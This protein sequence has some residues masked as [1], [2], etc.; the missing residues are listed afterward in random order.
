MGIVYNFWHHPYAMM[1]KAIMLSLE[2]VDI[3]KNYF[4]GN[5]CYGLI[6]V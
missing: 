3:L 2:C 5:M 6:Y 1:T 4:I